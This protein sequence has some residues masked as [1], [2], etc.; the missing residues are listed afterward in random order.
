[1]P[2][3]FDG[4]QIKRP[5]RNSNPFSLKTFCRTDAET[6]VRKVIAIASG[7]TSTWLKPNSAASIRSRLTSSNVAASLGMAAKAILHLV[8]KCVDV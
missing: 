5:R 7:P 3:L 8:G 1:M 2:G 4:L 6:F